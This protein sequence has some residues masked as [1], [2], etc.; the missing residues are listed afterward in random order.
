MAR[1]E[2]VE[3]VGLLTEKLKQSTTAVLTD[4][5][6]LSVGQ[7]SDLR[8]RFREA[9]VEY[10]VVKN[11]LA[12]RAVDEAGADQQLRE[13]FLGPT[14][15]AFS[16]GDDVGAPMR[17]INDFTRATRLKME[18]RGALVEGRV[19]GPTEVRSIA[20]LPSREALIGQLLGTL[21]S[22]VAQLVGALQAPI[23]ELTALLE[24]YRQKIDTA[25]A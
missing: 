8:S 2:K 15:V 9:E 17:L 6:G 4:Y 7:L 21:Q 3:E 1:A 14:A 25:S 12:R 23:Q 10:R 13:L 18:V 5:R 16:Y 19:L 24:S 22:P 11:T 20:D